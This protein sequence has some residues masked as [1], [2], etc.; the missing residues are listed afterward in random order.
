MQIWCFYS[1]WGSSLLLT[2]ST[3]LVKEVCTLALIF[4]KVPFACHLNPDF[5]FGFAKLSWFE[6]DLRFL[7]W[8]LFSRW[9][10]FEGIS[11]I[12]I[13]VQ[14]ILYQ[15]NSMM[16]HQFSQNIAKHLRKNWQSTLL[17]FAKSQT[18]NNFLYSGMDCLM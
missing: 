10:S 6:S 16:Y 13:V 12:Y 8:D 14:V 2:L 5:C 4:Q 7:D 9:I 11:W 1:N 15:S 18:K 3:S 17:C